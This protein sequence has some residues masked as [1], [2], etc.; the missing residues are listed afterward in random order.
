LHNSSYTL[1]ACSHLR[2]FGFHIFGLP[3][4]MNRWWPN[5]GSKREHYRV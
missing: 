2:S 3:S 1:S 5:C 4:H